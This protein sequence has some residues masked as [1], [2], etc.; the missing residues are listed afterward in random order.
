[1]IRHT[2]LFRFN[3]QASA[4]VRQAVLD[5]LGRFPDR[6]PAMRRFGLG[7]NISGRDRTF[8]HVLTVE[9]GSRQELEDY[10]NSSEHERFTD[11]VFRPAIEARVIGSVDVGPSSEGDAA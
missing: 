2:L 8:S 11:E 10:L 3:P 4:A 9:F 7:E 6:F 5:G 1:M